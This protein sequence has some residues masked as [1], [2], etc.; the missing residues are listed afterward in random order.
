V[1]VGAGSPK[2]VKEEGGQP[3]S[4]NVILA[5]EC[6]QMLSVSVIVIEKWKFDENWPFQMNL[7][8]HDPQKPPAPNK[9][10]TLCI[11]NKKLVQGEVG[12]G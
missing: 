1:K 9:F 8:A 12:Q 7:A 11:P 10:C 5:Q 2:V 4:H 6:P 3:F